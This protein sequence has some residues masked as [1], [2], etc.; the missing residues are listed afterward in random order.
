MKARL[1]GFVALL[2]TATAASLAQ[3]HPFCC[4]FHR[5]TC[6]GTCGGDCGYSGDGSLAAPVSTHPLLAATHGHPGK[7]F[8]PFKPNP[9]PAPFPVHPF[10]RSP[11]DYFMMDDP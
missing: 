3:A 7:W 6:S 11:R 1:I 8:A 5:G 9:G 2:I 10:A 4:L